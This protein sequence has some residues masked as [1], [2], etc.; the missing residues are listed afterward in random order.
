[1]RSHQIIF[2]WSNVVADFSIYICDCME[3]KLTAFI[4]AFAN[5]SFISL[6][7][8]HLYLH[9]L[10]I[11]CINH[12]LESL[13]SVSSLIKIRIFTIRYRRALLA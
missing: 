1:M 3:S 13:Y 2:Y 12:S 11:D 4:Q 10:S 5:C 6:V 7:N 9:N 8:Y